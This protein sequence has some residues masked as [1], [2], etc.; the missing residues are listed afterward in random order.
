M[1]RWF[2]FPLLLIIL[3]GCNDSSEE[4]YNNSFQNGLDYI[5]AEDFI[6]AEVHFEQAL[7]VKPDDERATRMLS[8]IELY[9]SAMSYF[10]SEQYDESIEELLK[11]KDIKDGSTGMIAI[12]DRFIA[13]AEE[14]IENL[15]VETSDVE[16]AEIETED[17]DEYEIEEEESTNDDEI[18]LEDVQIENTEI[19]NSDDVESSEEINKTSE[20]TFGN[21]VGNYLMFYSEPFTSDP[22]YIFVLTENAIYS[23]MMSSEWV[24]GNINQHWVDDDI[25]HLDVS[26]IDFD[27]NIEG[28]NVMKMSLVTDNNDKKL[29]IEGADS[30]MYKVSDKT[31]EDYGISNPASSWVD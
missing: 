15:S 5:A 9:Q 8:Q 24:M 16:A 31:L 17:N 4:A 25:L 27:G 6:R 2:L 19:E 23:G 14:A 13:T 26:Y 20:N 21:Y 1:K 10:D 11:L 12:A 29:Y 7:E 3:T 18:V 30:E 22:D 28:T